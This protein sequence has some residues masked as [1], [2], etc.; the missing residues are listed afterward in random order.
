MDK[1][2]G[3]YGIV[4]SEAGGGKGREGKGSPAPGLGRPRVGVRVKSAGRS[5]RY[6]EQCL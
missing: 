6:C 4:Y 1:I 2:A 3:V 5:H